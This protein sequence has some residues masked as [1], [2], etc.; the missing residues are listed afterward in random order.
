VIRGRRAIA[1][2]TSLGLP[3]RLVPKPRPDLAERPPAS[4]RLGGW[5]GDEG[6]AA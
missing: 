3:A 6:R 5:I 2:L 4:V 1:W